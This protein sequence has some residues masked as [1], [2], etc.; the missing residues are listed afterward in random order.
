MTIITD[1]VT[2]SKGR[3]KR[4]G[5]KEDKGERGYSDHIPVTVRHKVAK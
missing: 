1:K 5:D 3:P 2:D 4:F